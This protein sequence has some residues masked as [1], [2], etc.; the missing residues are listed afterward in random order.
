[1]VEQFYL[2]G[3]LSFLHGKYGSIL[4]GC[5][6]GPSIFKELIKIHEEL[7]VKFIVLDSYKEKLEIH[8]LTLK[9]NKIY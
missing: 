2:K 7:W 1:M 5:D 6:V 9:F 8:F 3:F 4:N